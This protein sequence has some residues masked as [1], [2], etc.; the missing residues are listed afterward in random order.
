METRRSNP[1]APAELDRRSDPAAETRVI[2][3][4]EGLGDR[5]R[6][7]LSRHL[8]ELEA[9]CVP[10]YLAAMGELA[11]SPAHAVVGPVEA[12]ADL[13]SE[14]EHAMRRLSPT[15][16]LVLVAPADSYRDVRSA[17]PG[18]DAVLSE[19]VEPAELAEALGL[20]AQRTPSQP[21]PP[22]D[23]TELGDVDLV[24]A[25]LTD[26]HQLRSLALQ[27]AR[28]RSGIDELDW[29]RGP[30][31]VP[32]GRTWTRVA[33]LGRSLGV[34]HG[35]QEAE[36]DLL[37]SW[38]AWMGRW[39]TLAEQMRQLEHL[40]THDELTGVYNRRYFD[41][42][43]EKILDR[44]ADDRSQVTLL[45]FDIDDFKIYNDRYGHAAGDDI[46]REAAKLMQSFV[47]DHDVV[48]RI[49]GDE[50]AVIF[51]D[52]GVKRQPDSRHPDSVRQAA[53][54]FQKA[55]CAHRFPKLADEAPGTL[56][57]S[58]GLAS[59]PWD[60]RRPEELLNE[61]DQMALRSKRQGKNAITFGPGALRLCG[62][63]PDFEERQQGPTTP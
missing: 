47:R 62:G 10:G 39:L 16:R 33:W 27:L 63:T 18:F 24:E 61:A 50:F 12:L 44:A 57:I 55:I 6:D 51:W 46:L 11:R 7:L 14:A 21:A 45:V 48:A 8:P 19:P 9:V 1:T 54:R 15:S 42:F 59:F 26:R 41:S 36:Q 28:S 23:D 52:A 49:G 34:L 40:S 13:G 38:A 30:D 58:G 32:P 20:A 53:R 60:G 56:T 17:W 25:L 29:A 5:L 37:G 2:V 22:D 3:V 31:D 43:L 4:D 35:P